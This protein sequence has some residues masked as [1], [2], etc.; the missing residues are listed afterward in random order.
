M[1]QELKKRLNHRLDHIEILAFFV[2]LFPVTLKFLIETSNFIFRVIA[3]LHEAITHQQSFNS[4]VLV[5]AT[6]DIDM[7][8]V[9]DN[10]LLVGKDPNKPGSWSPILSKAC[11]SS[12]RFQDFIKMISN[13]DVI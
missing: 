1:N 11:L 6:Y 12:L 4:C 10:N 3:Y 9:P 13:E 5:Q 7:A 2:I 8:L